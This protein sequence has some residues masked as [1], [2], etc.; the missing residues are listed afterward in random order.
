M[1]AS[2]PR[3]LSLVADGCEVADL[4]R[5]GL[6]VTVDA[7]DALLEP[8]G[9]ERDVEVDQ[10][11]AVVL[12]VDALAGGVGGEQDPHLRSWPGPR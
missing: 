2:W 7:A 11:V 8:V 3:T 1:S 6:A 5:L 4:G 10:S 9:V 12:Q